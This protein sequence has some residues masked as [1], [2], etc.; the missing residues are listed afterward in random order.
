[1]ATPSTRKSSPHSVR[2]RSHL[3][4]LIGDELI[5][6]DSLAVFELV[7]NAYDAD[8]TEVRVVLDVRNAATS[9]I[10]V[11]DNGHGM[12]ASDVT[13]KWLVIA[14]NAK[15]EDPQ[16]RTPKFNRLPLGEKGVGRFA[17]FKLGDVVTLTTRSNRAPEIRVEVDWSEL[18]A[19]GDY[20]EDLSVDVDTRAE[21]KHFTGKATGTRIR[22]T[23]LNK[24]EWLRKD[25]RRLFRL[26]TS[27]AS[28]F[29]SPDSF[30]VK[31]E[32]PGRES[33]I[34]DM[35]KPD[36]FLDQALW[37]FTFSLDKGRM[38]WA[39]E[40][41]PPHWKGL[42]PSKKSGK[43]TPV[44]LVNEGATRG[45]RKTSDKVLLTPEMMGGIGK[46]EGIVYAY[47]R[48]NEVLKTSGN[49]TQ[50]KEWLDDQAGVRI[51]RDGIRVFNYGEP[52]DDWLGLDAMRVNHPTDW[53]GS[54]SVVAAIHLSLA[55]SRALAEKTNR[56]GFSQNE[57]YARLHQTVLSVFDHFMRQ[58]REDRTALD[59]FIK[60]KQPGERTPKVFDAIDRLKN[61]LKRH[62]EFPAIKRDLEA[63]QERFVEVQ[64]VMVGAGM[65]GLNLAIIFH[66]VERSVNGLSASVAKT[67]DVPKLRQQIEHLRGL[68]TTFA[69]LLRKNEAKSVFASDLVKSAG[70]MR[71]HRFLFHRTVFSAPLLTEEEE[72]FRLRVPANLIV[73]ALGNLIDNSIYW[74]RYRKER[75]KTTKPPAIL[76]TS[77]WDEKARSGFL[78]V[79]DNGPG[80]RI[81]ADKAIEPFATGRPGGMGLG[82]YFANIVMEQCG[83]SLTIHDAEDFRD[84]AKFSKSFDG[85]AVVLRFGVQ[86]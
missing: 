80:F 71:E 26:V 24:K 32:V 72:D 19:M 53:L 67:V 56:E 10:F 70:A 79:V 84:E 46:I 73:S 12:T 16:K 77:D 64:D 82:L 27:L 41:R 1:M 40:F 37:K 17:A 50:L 45:A 68:L 42:K 60:G 65:A 69:P 57:A 35:L 36:E 33:D 38:N 78:A 51:F 31:F 3:L 28:P 43:A 7:K 20:I 23:D 2:A 21:P 59:S 85:A 15:R 22:I 6:D 8:A 14:T 18:L 55:S 34:A 30:I 81:S 62:E 76:V 74:T 25:L 44:Q 4:R 13:D 52:N 86:K 29:E 63:I 47:Y 75:D 48:R 83:G 66:E 58:H 54:K 9:R 49:Q 11:E 5:G 39:Y 61:L